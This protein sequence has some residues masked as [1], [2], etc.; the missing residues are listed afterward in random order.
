MPSDPFDQGGSAALLDLRKEMHGILDAT[1]QI[2]RRVATIETGNNADRK[3]M[4]SDMEGL[5]K[6]H[7][8]EIERQIEG[9]MHEIGR[10][11]TEMEERII[12]AAQESHDEWCSEELPGRVEKI[13]TDREETKRESRIAL[14]KRIGFWFIVGAAALQIISGQQT[15]GD[16]V[17]TIARLFF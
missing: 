15:L 16:M 2:E 8:H 1:T 9:F 4:R 17:S 7:R 5:L 13:V 14:A 10:K 11:F 12:K 3:A 6:D